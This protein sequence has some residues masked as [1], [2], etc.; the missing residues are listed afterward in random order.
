MVLRYVQ[1]GLS[2]DRWLSCEDTSSLGVECI[3]FRPCLAVAREKMTPAVGCLHDGFQRFEHPPDAYGPA[4]RL[5]VSID[6]AYRWAAASRRSRIA[7]TSSVRSL[8]VRSIARS[9]SRCGCRA[10][11]QARIFNR[12]VIL[13]E[14]HRD[15]CEIREEELGPG[16]WRFTPVFAVRHGRRRYAGEVR[17][18]G[19]RQAGGLLQA[20]DELPDGRGRCFAHAGISALLC[21]ILNK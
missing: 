5:P 16:M 10:W 18:V 9:P 13:A 3:L 20:P 14:A 15:V 2:P 1:K 19:C 8:R 11:S 4:G 7:S 21:V 12:A 17:Y 6:G